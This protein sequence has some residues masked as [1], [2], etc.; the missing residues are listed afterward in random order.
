MNPNR[1]RSASYIAGF[2]IDGDAENLRDVIV[3]SDAATGKT[4]EICGLEFPRPLENIKRQTDDALVFDQ[5]MNPNFGGRYAGSFN[6]GKLVAY[7]I[8]E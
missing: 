4:F 8:I 1:T 2:A 7:G 3:V 6:T 5:W